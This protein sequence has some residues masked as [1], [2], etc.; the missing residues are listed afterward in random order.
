MYKETS[1]KILDNE[2]ADQMKIKFIFQTKSVDIS[3]IIFHHKLNFS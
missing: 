3:F 1:A 2:D